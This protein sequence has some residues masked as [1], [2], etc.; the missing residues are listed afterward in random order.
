MYWPFR[1]PD[2]G[3]LLYQFNDTFVAK[4]VERPNRFI[5]IT[6]RDGELLRC[7]LH[8]PGRLKELIYPGNRIL[9]RRSATGKVPYRVIAAE[10][11]GIWVLI[12]AGIHPFLARSFLKDGFIAEYSFLG[13][14]FDFAYLTGETPV[15][16]EVKGCSLSIDGIATFPDAP[17]ARG[18]DQLRRLTGY[19][20]EGGTAF[21]FVLV[22]APEPKCFTTNRVTDAAFDSAFR[23]F[24]NSGGLFKA[25]AFLTYDS[26]IRYSGD[27][28]LCL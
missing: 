18:T 21:I 10:R 4:V 25:S 13:K 12:D 6:R 26:G 1:D 14:R 8:D 28:E 3:S 24:L 9:L 5:V 20:K 2:P 22:F 19:V 17:T 15:I 11:N 16:I 7:H 23:E 27:I